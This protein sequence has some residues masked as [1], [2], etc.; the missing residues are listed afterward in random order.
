MTQSPSVVDCRFIFILYCRYLRVR[1]E[2]LVDK[3]N[4]TLA[5]VYEYLNLPF[6]K[7]VQSV[8]FAR[9]HAENV[10]GTNG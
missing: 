8:A 6:S 2:D 3:T 9:T 4:S 10:T 5:S 7:H 1:Y